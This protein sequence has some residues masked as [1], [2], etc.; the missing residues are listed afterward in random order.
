M[1]PA[2][3]PWQKAGTR[4]VTPAADRLAM[5]ELTFAGIEGIEISPIEIDRGG[6]SYT[7][8]TVDEL[9]HTPPP[10]A[11]VLVIV[12]SDVA[13]M[14]DTWRR[15]E[16]LRDRATIA[17]YARAGAAGGQAPAGWKSVGFDV[18]E[19]GVSSTLVRRRVERG[20]PIDG[21]VVAAVLHYIRD[22]G[23]YMGAVA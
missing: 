5:L 2:N 23:L 16:R 8:D 6:E 19:I 13:P 22:R 17:V 18:P 12:G 14:L 21:L 7:A 3:V 1:I 11:E 9:A 4:P 20:Q 15:P 10:P